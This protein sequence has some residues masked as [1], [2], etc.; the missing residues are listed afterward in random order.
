MQRTLTM[1]V[2]LTGFKEHGKDEACKL[3]GELG[4]TSISSSWYA[5]QKFIFDTLKEDFGYATAQECY[6]DRKDKRELWFRL[7]RDYNDD[8][9]TRLADEIFEEGF[10]IYNGMRNRE[11]FEAIKQKYP[12]LMVIWIDASERKPAESSESMELTVDDAHMI[13]DNNGTIEQLA[14][15]VRAVYD[16]LTGDLS[17]QSSPYQATGPKL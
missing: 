11:E 9:L 14:D 13:I 7:I 1:P 6:D 15:Q 5:C 2:I 8:C 4:L 17:V 16:V 3:L 10:D 12:D